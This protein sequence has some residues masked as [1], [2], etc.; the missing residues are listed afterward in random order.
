MPCNASRAWR[1]P[2]PT[3]PPPLTPGHVC[4]GKR[5]KASD[6]LTATMV[7]VGLAVIGVSAW[8]MAESIKATDTVIINFWDLVYDVQNLVSLAASHIH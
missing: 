3:H 5:Q 1:T 4:A 7:L 6:I 8:G 2:H